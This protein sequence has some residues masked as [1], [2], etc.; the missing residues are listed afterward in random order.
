[1]RFILAVIATLCTVGTFAM[2]CSSRTHTLSMKG[3]D[4]RSTRL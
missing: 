3:T 2:D 1:M 4:V